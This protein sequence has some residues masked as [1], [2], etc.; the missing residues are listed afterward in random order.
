MQK[1]YICIMAKERESRFVT[2]MTRLKAEEYQ[3]FM[4]KVKA[5]G[6]SRAGYLRMLI[7]LDKGL[8]QEQKP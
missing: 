4:K 3:A 7:L 6:Q 8:L 1:H 5:I 2:V